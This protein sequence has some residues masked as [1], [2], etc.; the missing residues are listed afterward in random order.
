MGGKQYVVA[1]QH[2]V[3][4]AGN[5]TDEH[6]AKCIEDLDFLTSY[7]DVHRGHSMMNAWCQGL[8]LRRSLWLESIAFTLNTTCDT[9]LAARVR[10]IAFDSAFPNDVFSYRLF[11]GCGKLASGAA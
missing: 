8:L 2:L 4:W 10:F 11:A 6:F 5:A 7:L 3:E 1:P 9:F